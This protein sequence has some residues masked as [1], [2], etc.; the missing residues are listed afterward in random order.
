MSSK[1]LVVYAV[2]KY[3]DREGNQRDRWDRIGVAFR[4]SKDGYQIKLELLPAHGST[5]D[6]V[7]MPPRRKEDE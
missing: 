3:Q 4:N 6:I 7:A 5:A 2:S 1:H